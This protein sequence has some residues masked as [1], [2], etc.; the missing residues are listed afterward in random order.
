M[1]TFVEIFLDD[2]PNP[3]DPII[4]T[5]HQLLEYLERFIRRYEKRKHRKK[6]WK[7]QTINKTSLLKD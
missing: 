3:D 1:K 7:K 4:M 2:F 6:I 5:H